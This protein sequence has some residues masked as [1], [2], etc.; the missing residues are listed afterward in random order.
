VPNLKG[1]T[2]D[3]TKSILKAKK[4][5]LGMVKRE[6]DIDQRFDIILRQYPNPGQ[7]VKQGTAITVVLNSES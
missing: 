3:A 4:L 5:T 2:L 6:T 1:K 7:R